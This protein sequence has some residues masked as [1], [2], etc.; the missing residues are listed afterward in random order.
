MKSVSRK[1]SSLRNAT[2]PR[3][4]SLPKVPRRAAIDGY[5]ESGP[6]VEPSPATIFR[7]HAPCALKLPTGLHQLVNEALFP[8]G[9][10]PTSPIVHGEEVHLR[11]AR[12]H[13]DGSSKDMNKRGQQHCGASYINKQTWIIS[14][15]LMFGFLYFT[16]MFW[17]GNALPRYR[18]SQAATALWFWRCKSRDLPKYACTSILQL[19]EETQPVKYSH[20]MLLEEALIGSNAN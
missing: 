14:A 5:L 11:N 3:D 8:F 6:V 15:V 1:S 10:S 13:L 2:N 18:L 19:F 4:D 7:H 16:G 9:A 17:H 12:G 20:V